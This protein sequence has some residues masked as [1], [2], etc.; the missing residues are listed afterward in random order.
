MDTLHPNIVVLQRFE[1]R[2]LPS[3]KDLSTNDVVWRFVDGKTRGS[4]NFRQRKY[5]IQWKT[6]LPTIL[7]GHLW[8]IPI[9]SVQISF[10][11]AD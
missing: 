3:A 10:N 7:A 11:N 4:V 9:S 5:R 8:Y 2:D 1:L 6:A